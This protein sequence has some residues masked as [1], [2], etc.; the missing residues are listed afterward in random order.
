M[1]R[2]EQSED[3]G[4]IP[5]NPASPAKT[6][7]SL[8]LATFLLFYNHL[9]WSVYSVFQKALFS[10]IDGFV[11]QI[12]KTTVQNDAFKCDLMAGDLPVRLIS[13]HYGKNKSFPKTYGR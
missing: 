1:S 4:F 13:H 11:L 2:S 12:W 3:E 7:K 5:S 9:Y 6:D 8:F 10:A